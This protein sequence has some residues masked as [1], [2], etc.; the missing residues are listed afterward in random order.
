MTECAQRM[1]VP[2][3]RQDMAT[4]TRSVPPGTITESEPGD[5]SLVRTV[6]SQP[7]GEHGAGESVRGPGGPLP[8]DGPRLRPALQ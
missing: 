3:G 1:R 7:R 6:Q 4:S 8:G 2:G 5:S